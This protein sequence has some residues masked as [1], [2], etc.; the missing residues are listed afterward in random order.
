[1]LECTCG[2]E[3]KDIVQA[4]VAGAHEFAGSARLILADDTGP[5]DDGII[6]C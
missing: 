2:K 4:D 1:M 6:T 3:I 5:L